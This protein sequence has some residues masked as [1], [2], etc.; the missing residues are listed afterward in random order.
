MREEAPVGDPPV[1]AIVDDDERFLGTFAFRVRSFA[2]GEEILQSSEL[3][4]V[5]RLLLD[6]AMLGMS[7]LE[8]NQR[9]RT[10]G[11]R[12]PTVFVT[13]HSDAERT[14]HL[15]AAGAIAILPKP[16]DQQGLRRLVQRV[17][18]EQ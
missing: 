15:A 1:I 5:A 4:L 13:A 17:V 2:S 6:V 18:D 10:R 7:G 9:L 3:R 11:L 12:I 16:V 8:L 14:R